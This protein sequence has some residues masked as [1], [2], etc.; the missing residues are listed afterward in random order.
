MAW[1]QVSIAD[2]GKG[3]DPGHVRQLF[4]PF[5]TTKGEKGTGLGLWVTKDIIAKL[6]AATNDYIKTAKAQEFFETLGVE[7]TGGTPAEAKAFIAAEI[8]KWAPII[9]AANIEF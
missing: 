1:A 4:E 2:N 8:A 3:I 9:K 7:S 6:N 5:F